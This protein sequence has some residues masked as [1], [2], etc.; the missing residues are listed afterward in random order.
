MQLKN[1]KVPFGKIGASFILKF[2]KM[3]ALYNSE[4]RKDWSLAFGEIGVP[5]DA[6][7]TLELYS[8]NSLCICSDFQFLSLTH[9]DFYT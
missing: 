1:K 3:G 7:P 9:R 8:S 6:C 2:G 4:N 5:P